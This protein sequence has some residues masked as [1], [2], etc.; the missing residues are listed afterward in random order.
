MVPLLVGYDTQK[1]QRIRVVRLR[2]KDLAIQPGSLIELTA[3]MLLERLSQG[4]YHGSSH[5]TG[6]RIA[7]GCPTVRGGV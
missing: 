1:V 2:G 7:A 4:V 5:C 6:M 3:L